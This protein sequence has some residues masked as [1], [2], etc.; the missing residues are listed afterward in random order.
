MVAPVRS[1]STSTANGQRAVPS[2]ICATAS[3]RSTSTLTIPSTRYVAHHVIAN[4]RASSRVSR[5]PALRPIDKLSIP[6]SLPP[7]KHPHRLPH[8]I[9]VTHGLTDTF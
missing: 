2:A 4:L 3:P 9:P 6:S 7:D 8:F 5:T 1:L